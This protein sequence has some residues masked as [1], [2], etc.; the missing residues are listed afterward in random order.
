[1][2]RH[3]L[4]HLQ[5]QQAKLLDQARPPS[6]IQWN[7][8]IACVNQSYLEADQTRDQLEKTIALASQDIHMAYQNPDLDSHRQQLLA[9]A[10]GI[11]DPVFL[12]D[13]QGKYINIICNDSHPLYNKTDK[14]IGRSIHNCFPQQLAKQLHERIQHSLLMQSL[15]S[16]EYEINVSNDLRNFEARIL[17]A[18]LQIDGLQTVVFSAID[19]THLKKSSSSAP[20]PPDTDQL[21]ELPNRSRYIKHINQLISLAQRNETQFALLHID[22]NKFKDI[23]N[24]LG[25]AVGDHVLRTVSSRLVDT[26][27]DIDIVARISGN[28]FGILLEHVSDIFYLANTAERCIKS[29]KQP[30]LLD[31]QTAHIIPSIGIAVY[32]QDGL[33]YEDLLH[34]AEH[35]MF[36]AKTSESNDY[37]FYRPSLTHA[38]IERIQME[39]DCREALNNNAFF[40][41]YQPQVDARSGHIVAVEALIRWRHKKHGMIAPEK[42]IPLAERI[43]LI[44][45]LG[46]WVLDKSCW[47]LRQWID[48]GVAKIRMAVNVSALEFCQQAYPNIVAQ[49]LRKYDIEP[50]LIELEITENA[51]QSSEQSKKTLCELKKLGVIITIDDFGTGYSCLDSLAELPLDQLKIDRQFVKNSLEEN[52]HAIIIGTVITMAKALKLSVVAEGVETVDHVQYL[53]GLRCDI[54]QGFYFG[55]PVEPQLIPSLIKRSYD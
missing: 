42:F 45:Q 34:A 50:A 4:L 41:H 30:I 19:I 1:M 6:R 17:P 16:I 46:N 31:Q 55:K 24:A 11:S 22:L 18:H 23:N 9:I 49:T 29:I 14:L 32:P 36:A 28:E 54:F 51:F 43:G 39:K 35:A 7:R 38:A 12:I 13:E 27:R 2:K 3:Q 40:L 8:F 25:H 21:T 48:Q 15:T 37:A 53:T 47:Q 20:Y 26:F 52:K 10:R 5:L 33:A 44:S